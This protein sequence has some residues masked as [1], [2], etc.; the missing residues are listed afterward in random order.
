MLE[1]VGKYL[2]QSIAYNILETS[3]VVIGITYWIWIVKLS[4]EK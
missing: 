1:E 3:T 2:N 4:L